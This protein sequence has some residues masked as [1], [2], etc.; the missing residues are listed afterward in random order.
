MA[1]KMLTKT[2]PRCSNFSNLTTRCQC[3]VQLFQVSNSIPQTK[4]LTPSYSNSTWLVCSKVQ[5]TNIKCL[6]NKTLRI[7]CSSQAWCLPTIYPMASKYSHHKCNRILSHGFYLNLSHW[8]NLVCLS[9][10]LPS[11]PLSKKRLIPPNLPREIKVPNHQ[12]IKKQIIIIKSKVKCFNSQL[13]HSVH[14]T[15]AIT[16]NYPHSQ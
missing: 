14:S 3:K 16:S 12:Q 11:E 8:F 4:I 1:V 6:C 2:I 10:D 15:M 9:Q 5:T 7:W 13:P